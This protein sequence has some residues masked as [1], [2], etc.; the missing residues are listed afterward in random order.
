MV[1]KTEGKM[2][3]VEAVIGWWWAKGPRGGGE[4]KGRRSHLPHV[5]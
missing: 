4:V 1:G 2:G 3:C 5:K